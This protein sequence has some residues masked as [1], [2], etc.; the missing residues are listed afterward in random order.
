M[1]DDSLNEEESVKFQINGV[2]CIINKSN[3][4]SK[5]KKDD[6]ILPY[7]Q[8]FNPNKYW[9]LIMYITIFSN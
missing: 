4:L 8:R 6:H 1:F 2:H 3:H 5:I 9:T 7:I